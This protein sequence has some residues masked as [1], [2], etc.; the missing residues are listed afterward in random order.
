MQ[1]ESRTRSIPNPAT[2]P[3][4]D[5]HACC[6]PWPCHIKVWVICNGNWV[7]QAHVIF[8][9]QWPGA[10]PDCRL[11]THLR[12]SI[13][14][15]PAVRALHCSRNLM[16]NSLC[17]GCTLTRQSHSK[18]LT[19]LPSDRNE[20]E[21]S[22]ARTS[23]SLSE[24]KHSRHSR[25]GSRACSSRSRSKDISLSTQNAFRVKLSKC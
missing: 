5:L 19:H 14:R 10:V 8:I 23:R 13:R 21:P 11:H 9:R 24:C 16:C 1:S 25:C 2:R 22:R 17:G 12:S 3:A 6:L 18:H 4:V 7:T 20:S 15:G